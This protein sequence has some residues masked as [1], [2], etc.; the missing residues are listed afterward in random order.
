MGNMKKSMPEILHN[1]IY[2]RRV[3]DLSGYICKFLNKASTFSGKFGIIDTY[4][5]ESYIRIVS[6]D[7]RSI[8]D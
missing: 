7:C 1:G 8:P 6:P 2:M 5:L 4:Y 3:Q